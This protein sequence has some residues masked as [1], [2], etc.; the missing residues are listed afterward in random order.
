MGF[1]FGIIIAGNII[2]NVATP[3]T[4]AI[5][6]QIWL[7]FSWMNTGW[8]VQSALAKNDKCAVLQSWTGLSPQILGAGLVLINILQ[9]YNW[10]NKRY[11]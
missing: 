6:L 1:L 5:F 3:K 7:G 11:I 2:D 9:V 8:W 4:L 10:F